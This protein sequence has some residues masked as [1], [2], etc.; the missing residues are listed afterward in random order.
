MGATGYFYDPFE[1]FRQK[2]SVPAFGYP[3]SFEGDAIFSLFPFP[4]DPNGVYGANTFS[5][6]LPAS[7]RG[8]LASARL[9][10]NF[11][12]NGHQ[13][14]ATA[15]FN[16]TDDWREIPVTGGALFSTLRPRVRT[17]NFSSYLNGALSHT[18]L[19]QFRFSYGRTRLRFDEVRDTTH[20]RPSR[21]SSNEPFLLNAALRLNNT[22][23]VCLNANCTLTAPNTGPVLYETDTNDVE[24]R[25][26]RIG[27]INIA[28]F[29]PVGVDV[30]NFPQRRVN[31]TYQFADTL[32]WQVGGG[33]N[34]VFGA[35]L[36]VTNLNSFL[37]RNSR[38]LLTFNGN[39]T[40]IED[41]VFPLSPINLAAAGVPSGAFL[42]LADPQKGQAEIRL[43]YYQSNFFAQDEW[44]VR[45]NLSVSYGLR[46]EYNT[47]PAERDSLIERT[48]TDPILNDSAVSG[49]QKFLANRRRIFDPDRNNFAP[50]VNVA[51]APNFFG[52]DRTTV[53]RAGYGLYYDQA[54]GA[55]VS[56]SRNV[57][58]NFL[59]VNTGGFTNDGVFCFRAC[60]HTDQPRVNTGGF[61]N[62]GVFSFFNPSRGEICIAFNQSGQCIAYRP[63][64]QPGT[65]NTRN[66][67]LTGKNILDGFRDEDV[68]PNPFSFTLPARRFPLP[69]AHQYAVTFEQQLTRGLIASVA[70]V[71]TT[72]RNL[73]RA[74]TPN[75][76]PNNIVVPL[77]SDVSADED[78]EA[79]L[80]PYFIGA[81]L[82]PKF[83]RPTKGLGAV[84]L[85]ETASRSQYH[86]LQTQLRGRMTNLNFQF[87]YTL[88]KALDDVSDIFDL[89]GASALP[90]NSLKPDERGPANF[91]ARHRVAYQV[92]Y[93]LPTLSG[94]PA[95]RRL[96]FGGWEILSTGQFQTG[97]PFTV[98]SIFDFNL[99]GNLTDRLNPT[100][101]IQV[102]GDRRQPL[103]LVE[104]A[105]PINAYPNFGRDG[106][107]GRNAFRAGNYL[108][109][110]LAVVKNFNLTEQQRVT[111]RAEFF[112]FINRA[113]FGVPVRFLE[114]PGFGQATDTITPGRRVQ[115]ALKYSF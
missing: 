12:L 53:I 48:F 113:N 54:I 94:S 68:F 107:V 5:Q 28:G 81:T 15:R 102:T 35:D 91:D 2:Q 73:L 58:P 41:R 70:Y 9:D 31:D 87:N 4:N 29:S 80:S 83:G 69:M 71:G 27:Q 1:S 85:Y 16:F 72:G 75:L 37:P 19:N 114:A 88:S 95:A 7:A 111:L 90:Q 79:F 25:L 3:T 44:R 32:S 101:R 108:L 40:V 46:Y 10:G 84:T 92:T 21:I 74:T 8:N 103:R 115:F 23:P 86:A 52:A 45:S 98:N 63:L 47:P 50:R 6:E 61:T 36:R 62:D 99:D 24:S 65:L 55:V 56:Q 112:N 104:P 93:A 26:G 97:Q 38:T 96:F 110:N 14:T 34:A 60:P 13:Q 66:S 59:T 18:L 57:I 89:A 11:N 67:A 20:L 100:N 33:H 77:Q 76:G 78:D 42:S 43:R 51:Y 49:V 106:R 22:L 109:L 30:F 39:P 64:V 82:A 17:H 105:N